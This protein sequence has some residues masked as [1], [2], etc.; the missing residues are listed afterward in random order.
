[1]VIFEITWAFLFLKSSSLVAEVA[2]Y[3][4]L[5]KAAV[6]VKQLYNKMAAAAVSL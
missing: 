6:G 5:L 4:G 3:F 1:V 2:N